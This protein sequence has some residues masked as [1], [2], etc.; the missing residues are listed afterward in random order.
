MAGDDGRLVYFLVPAP[1]EP[2][3]KKENVT[4]STCEAPPANCTTSCARRL[5]T[6]GE[7]GGGC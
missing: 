6:P 2:A 7:R 3:V 1:P 4:S 5:L